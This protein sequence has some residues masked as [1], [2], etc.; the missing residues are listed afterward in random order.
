LIIS[1]TKQSEA[2][3]IFANSN[4]SQCAECH[5]GDKSAHQLKL[6]SPAGFGVWAELVHRGRTSIDDLL[7]LVPPPPPQPTYMR[8]NLA[9]FCG[10]EITHL[11]IHT[12][13]AI[14]QYVSEK[15]R[16]HDKFLATPTFL[17]VPNV[18]WEDKSAHQKIGISLTSSF[19]GRA[20]DSVDGH[21]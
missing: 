3:Q 13:E 18:M 10:E 2:S 8:R 14:R 16:N 15:N 4:F 7:L 1:S 6:H 19:G 5:A 12:S 20:E 17:N 11:I 21:P 9:S